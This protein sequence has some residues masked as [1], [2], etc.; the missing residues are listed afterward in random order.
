M[1]W[2]RGSSRAPPCLLR[3]V[4]VAR[5][6]DRDSATGQSSSR[7]SLPRSSGSA[8]SSCSSAWPLLGRSTERRCQLFTGRRARLA[9]P[10]RLI[11]EVS[12]PSRLRRLGGG[13][14]RSAG[15]PSD[16]RGNIRRVAGARTNRCSGC[17]AELLDSRWAPRCPA[18]HEGHEHAERRKQTRP[19]ELGAFGWPDPAT[20][21][22]GFEAALGPELPVTRTEAAP[23]C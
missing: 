23:W 17:G 19:L 3:M 11:S 22:A 10:R 1:N 15:C 9:A 12:Q 2:R 8:R 14:A 5:P 7:F 18:C 21:S 13:F 20:L 6:S 4:W 16:R